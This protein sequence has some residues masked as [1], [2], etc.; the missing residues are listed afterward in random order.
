MTHMSVRKPGVSWRGRLPLVATLLLLMGAIIAAPGVSNARAAQKFFTAT[1]DPSTVS[2]STTAQSFTVTITNCASGISNCGVPSSI[3]LGSAKIL[4]PTRFSNVSFVSATSPTKGPWTGSGTGWDGT[5]IKAASSGSNKLSPGEVLN[6]TFTADVLGCSNSGSPYQF[7]TSA[8]GSTTW[9]QFGNSEPFSIV[10]PPGQPQVAI[11]GCVLHA[12]ETATDPATGETL[13]PDG[14][15]GTVIVS[16]GGALMCADRPLGDQWSSYHLPSQFNITPGDDYVPGPVKTLRIDF[17]Q[18]IS[19]G[20]SSWYLVC[21]Q[22]PT[23]FT[24]RSGNVDTRGILPACYNPASGE[25]R[26]EPCVAEQYLT[27]G[28]GSPPWSV[29]AN[30]IVIFLRLPPGDPQGR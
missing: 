3:A 23:E 9:D 21:Y 19:G 10:T 6:V 1:I 26:P 4:V 27:T 22:S 18:S 25:T 15:E 2:G 14:F 20:D 13:T 16:F 30:K 28:P 12:G 24:D 17:N 29:G 11:N 7:T 8:Y 5:Y